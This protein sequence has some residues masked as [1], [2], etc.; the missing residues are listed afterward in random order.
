VPRP[1]FWLAPEREAF[2]RLRMAEMIL[3]LWVV[4]LGTLAALNHLTLRANLDAAPG[5]GHGPW[6]LLAGTLVAALSVILTYVRL[7]ARAR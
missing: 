3:W 2:T 6:I 4:L 1:G 5:L 7:F